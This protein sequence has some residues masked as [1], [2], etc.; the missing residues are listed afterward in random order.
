MAL[1]AHFK[2][3]IAS[4]LSAKQIEN[5][6][7][8]DNI[9]YEVFPAEST[10]IQDDSIDLITVAQALHWF[11]FERFYREAKRVMHRRGVITAWAYGLHSVS[12]EVDKVTYELYEN[13]LGRYWP[14]ERRY[15]EAKYA[16]IPFPF[17]QVSVPEF[18]MELEW[19]VDALT[20]YIYTWSSVQK[21]VEKN[22]RDPVAEIVPLLREA[23]G[24]DL[25]RRVVWPLYVKAGRSE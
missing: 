23:W 3:V 22:N 12:P 18:R 10:P 16:T 20:S 21:F 13:I 5:A 2:Q 25:K 17:E 8:R 7:L 19:D 1:A 15:I 11:D 4:D 9:R 24:S 14:P 6:H